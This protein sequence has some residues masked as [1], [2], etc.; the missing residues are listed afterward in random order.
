MHHYANLWAAGTWTQG[1]VHA[2]WALC[3]LGHILDP[4]VLL[5]ICPW[6]IFENCA[7]IMQTN[8][9]GFSFSWVG[10]GVWVMLTQWKCQA[11]SLPWRRCHSVQEGFWQVGGRMRHVTWK[12]WGILEYSASGTWA[13]ASL[14]AQEQG[15]DWGDCVGLCRLEMPRGGMYQPYAWMGL[16]QAEC[17]G[18]DTPRVSPT[19][20]VPPFCF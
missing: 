2:V 14:S 9:S 19:F 7:K 10:S 8:H 15:C 20:T 6:N 1:S 16:L 5:L 11:H 13:R 4:G 3:Q 17:P 18:T 12:L